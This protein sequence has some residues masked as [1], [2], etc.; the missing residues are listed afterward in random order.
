MLLGQLSRAAASA[1]RIHT[2]LA[3]EPAIEDD[4]D[5]RPLAARPGRGALRR[6]STFGYGRVRPV[7]DGLDLEIRGGEAIALVGATASGKT[8]RR[9]PDPALLRRH[10]RR[11]SA[12]TGSRRARGAAARRAA[13]GRHRVRG[14]VPVLRHR[15]QQHRV[16]R[17]RSDDG[18]GRARGAARGRRRVRARPARRVTTRSSAST[19]TRSPVVNGNASR[20]RARCSPT[21]AS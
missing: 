6:M 9:P 17:S 7:L 15:A 2:V 3:T 11:G 16:R 18:T 13:R 5:A 14:H 20:S 19:A 8:H 10:R 4:P 12:S 21:R 1:G